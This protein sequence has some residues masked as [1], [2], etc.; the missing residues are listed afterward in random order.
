MTDKGSEF[1]HLEAV[2]N[3]VLDGLIT[4]D[5][6]GIIQSFNPA[7]V[8]IFG[9]V[10]EEVIGHNVK[11]LMPEPYHS[12][13]DHYLH[14][15]LHSGEKK[16]IGV[17][18]EVVAQRKDGTV[19]PME[20]GI[21]EMQVEGERMF[22]GSIRDITERKQAEEDIEDYVKQLTRS[23]Q[24][25]DDF[26]YIASH[27]LKEPL[28]GLRN[29]ALFLK[30]DYEDVLDAGAIKRLDRI[31]FLSNRMEKLVDDLLYFSRLRRQQLA[32]KQ[33][34][35][36]LVIKDI[37]TLSEPML[38]DAHAKLVVPKPLPTIVCDETRVTELFRNLI[39][40]A[41]KYNDKVDKRIEIG[42]TIDN[43]EHVFYVKDNGIGID[44]Q[45]YD[46]IFRIFKR[47]N[48][49]DDQSKGTGSGLTFVKKIVE[50]HHGRIW[51]DSTQGVGTTF[52]FTLN[53]DAVENK[54]D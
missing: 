38:A 25:L 26:A 52:Y 54:N 15:Y 41:I 28:R 49:E 16:V 46:D 35:L 37:E 4:I 50:R 39:T 10:P 19:F 8:R 5:N 43:D 14:N 27:D 21:N 6:K 22:V 9:Y 45:F 24:E 12:E 29:N 3:T 33:T 47:L 48:D 2:L 34:D 51:L 13:H 7:A 20:L 31:Q 32:I 1:T 30:E 42:S 17:G 18:R 23:N 36:N 11:K 40:N 53:L 44:A